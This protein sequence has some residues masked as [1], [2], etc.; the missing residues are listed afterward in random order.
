MPRVHPDLLRRDYCY[1]F[2]RYYYWLEQQEVQP[3]GLVVFDELEKSRSHL[4]LWQMARYFQTTAKGLRRAALVVPE[5]FFVHSDLTTGVQLADLVAYILSWGF[6]LPKMV[7]P[8]REELAQYAKDVVE[9][10][11]KIDHG[12]DARSNKYTLSFAVINK[13][14]TEKSTS[15]ST[16]KKAM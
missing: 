3:M 16:T 5:P 11:F 12:D 4:L 2:E 1:L 13:L 15:T 8:A 14:V 9:M 6:R 7:K 10:E